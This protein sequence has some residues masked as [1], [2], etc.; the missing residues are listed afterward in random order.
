[1]ETKNITTQKKVSKTVCF[2]SSLKEL[3]QVIL[4]LW[5]ER[6]LKAVDQKGKFHAALS[7]DTRRISFIEQLADDYEYDMW[8]NTDVFCLDDLYVPLD[9]ELSAAHLLYEKLIEPLE[10]DKKIFHF[11]PFAPTVHR[12]ATQYATDVRKQL[13]VQRG[14]LPKFDL[15]VIELKKDG[16]LGAFESV[17]DVVMENDSL[18]TVLSSA[19]NLYPRISLSM[20]VIKNAKAII[21]IAQGKDA[22]DSLNK[23]FEGAEG[24]TVDLLEGIDGEL[25]IVTDTKNTELVN[26]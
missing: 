6:A 22:Q 21:L 1:M 12:A 8:A 24:M 14:R 5:Q 25:I 16:K 20:P 19:Q 10:L 15:L 4:D 23:W 2:C 9:H 3:D 17:E 26:E 13:D 18:T 7:V 11:V